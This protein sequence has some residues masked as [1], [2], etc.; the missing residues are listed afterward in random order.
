RTIDRM[1]S[2]GPTRVI[3][4]CPSCNVHFADIV[5][6]RDGQRPDFSITPTP[7]YLAG[8][9]AGPEGLPWQQEV[10]ERVVLHA[11]AGRTDHPEGQRRSRED[12]DAVRS[13]L[14]AV[15][16]LEVIDVIVSDP[17]MDFDCGGAQQKLPREV[18][19]GHQRATLER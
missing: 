9:A 2:Y 14:E 1:E 4:W 18:F 6:G 19:R 7:T 8:L 16:G 12:R 5:M 15:P 13:L 10:N 3:M 11:H 17:E